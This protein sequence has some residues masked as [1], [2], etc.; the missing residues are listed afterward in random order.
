MKPLSCAL[1][2]V[3]SCVWSFSSLPHSSLFKLRQEKRRHWLSF[4]I[5]SMFRS[6]YWSWVLSIRLS[7]SLDSVLWSFVNGLSI[8]ANSW[9]ASQCRLYFVLTIIASSGYPV[10]IWF[11]IGFWRLSFLILQVEGGVIL[12]LEF[13]VSMVLFMCVVTELL[14]HMDTLLHC[15]CYCDWKSEL[16]C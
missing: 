9:C 10:H 7:I 1:V 5:Y 6:Y 2:V 11:W 16:V 3:K 12:I 15:W 8:L 14:L 13:G 4:G